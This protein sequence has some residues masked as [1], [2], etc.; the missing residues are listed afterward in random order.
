MNKRQIQIEVFLRKRP[1]GL[2]WVEVEGSKLISINAPELLDLLE[3]VIDR[4]K[5]SEIDF[6]GWRDIDHFDLGIII[7]LFLCLRLIHL[8]KI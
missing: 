8:W 1:L 6:T 7:L 2:V 4:N 5:L 3:G